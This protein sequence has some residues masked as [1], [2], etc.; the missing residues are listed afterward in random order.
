MSL[1]TVFLISYQI[2]QDDDDPLVLFLVA[3]AV[4]IAPVVICFV[5]GKRM[6]AIAGLLFIIPVVGLYFILIPTV[7]AI[8]IAKPNS[9]WA[10]HNYPPNGTKMQTAIAR[11]GQGQRVGSLVGENHKKM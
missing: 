3:L 6:M 8:R 2:S 11:L 7:G 10:R 9:W 5:K 4:V 1:Q